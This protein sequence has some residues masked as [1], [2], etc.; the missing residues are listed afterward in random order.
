MTATEREQIARRAHFCC[1]YCWSQRELSHDDFSIEHILPRAAGGAD[2][3]DN[4]ALS[5]QG[6]NN[7]KFTAVSATD[8][9]TGLVVPLY[10][11]RQDHWEEHFCWDEDFANLLGLTPKGRA[12]IERLDL[13]RPRLVNLRRALTLAGKHPPE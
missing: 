1:E 13:N 6:C 8:P 5:C 10:H 7:R 11:P 4:L 9:V 2:S 12:T 3:L